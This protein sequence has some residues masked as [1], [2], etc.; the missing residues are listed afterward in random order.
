ML[1]LNLFSSLPCRP[2][3]TMQAGAIDDD[4]DL[5]SVKPGNL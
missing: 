4:T 2:L 1:K 5:G 3:S